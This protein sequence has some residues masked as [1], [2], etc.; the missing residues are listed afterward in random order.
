MMM[1]TMILP[2]VDLNL[3]GLFAVLDKR[4]IMMMIIIIIII[5]MMIMIMMIKRC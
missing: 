3:S 4:L 1:M 5:K 2:E